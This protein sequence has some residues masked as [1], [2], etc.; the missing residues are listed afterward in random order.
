MTIPCAGSWLTCVRSIDKENDVVARAKLDAKKK[1]GSNPSAQPILL[2]NGQVEKPSPSDEKESYI[3]RRIRDDFTRLMNRQTKVFADHVSKLEP[4]QVG[5]SKK[6]FPAAGLAAGSDTNLIAAGTLLVDVLPALAEKEVSRTSQL[7]ADALIHALETGSLSPESFFD[8]IAIL[9][10]NKDILVGGDRVLAQLFSRSSS[11]GNTKVLRT[12]SGADSKLVAT[13]SGPFI[14]Y[15]TIENTETTP[16]SLS[17]YPHRSFP[18]TN[19]AS[20][21]MSPRERK[22]TTKMLG[23]SELSKRTQSRT[24]MSPRMSPTKVQTLTRPSKLRG[25]VSF[26]TSP[27][28]SRK[29]GQLTEEPISAAQDLNDMESASEQNLATSKRS[30]NKYQSELVAPPRN[31]SDDQKY[32]QVGIRNDL[33][34]NLL[35]LAWKASQEDTDDDSDLDTQEPGA[36]GGAVEVASTLSVQPSSGKQ[37]DKQ[38]LSYLRTC[39]EPTAR[40]HFHISTS[41]SASTTSPEQVAKFSLI[42]EQL[43]TSEANLNRAQ[44]EQVAALYG[45][46]AQGPLFEWAKQVGLSYPEIPRPFTDR[47]GWRFTGVITQFGEEIVELDGQSWVYPPEHTEQSQISVRRLKR[48][49]Q[50]EQERVFG[51]PPI[52]SNGNG[53]QHKRRRLEAEVEENVA[54]ERLMFE[55]RKAA[56]VRGLPCNK[57]LS[58]EELTSSI[59]TFDASHG[60]TFEEAFT[61]PATE[62]PIDELDDSASGQAEASE[63]SEIDSEDD[64]DYEPDPIVIRD[65]ETWAGSNGARTSTFVAANGRSGSLR[66]LRDRPSSTSSSAQGNQNRAMDLSTVLDVNFICPIILQS[67][68]YIQPTHAE[69]SPPASIT[70]YDIRP[71]ITSGTFN[72]FNGPI[73][74]SNTPTA[75]PAGTPTYMKL[76]F[77]LP[78]NQSSTS[79]GPRTPSIATRRTSTTSNIS[80]SSLASHPPSGQPLD[81]DNTNAYN[82]AKGYNTNNTNTPSNSSAHTTTADPGSPHGLNGGFPG[83]GIIINAPDKRGDGR[84]QRRKSKAPDFK[85]Q[86]QKAGKEGPKV[87]ARAVRGGTVLKFT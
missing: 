21:R 10:E 35:D 40:G 73:T 14:I 49:T 8:A 71:P 26:A 13:T 38:H 7:A 11:S 42:I 36:P 61:V 77:S 23:V 79:P 52:A 29:R 48:K 67:L 62:P 86:V 47:D 76:N 53:A 41:S 6:W 5:F 54:Y 28:P 2:S 46:L 83:G 15:N 25:S 19:S 45:Q 16:S 12:S 87:Q 65:E 56:E 78:R 43:P 55:V 32:A 50:L 34:K 20:A 58:W 82:A 70:K 64:S 24:P 59:K 1:F 17:R 33:V 37:N 57:A 60:I 3:R 69:M 30:M 9:A 75:S 81:V 27:P 80:T 68:T 18:T 72:T 74:S 31:A 4:F 44:V 63:I 66:K 51:F 22:P 39:Q 84:G 85:M